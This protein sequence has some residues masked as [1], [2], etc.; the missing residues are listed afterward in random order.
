M[1]K[2]VLMSMEEFIGYQMEQL[3]KQEV[4]LERH[5][6]RNSYLKSLNNRQS[7]II[8]ATRAG[9][10]IVDLDVKIDVDLGN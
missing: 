10:D 2:K 4:D 7:N 6:V 1:S 9:M 8:S 5:R 3:D